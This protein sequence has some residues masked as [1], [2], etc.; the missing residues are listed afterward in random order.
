MLMSIAL[1]KCL[2]MDLRVRKRTAKNGSETDSPKVQNEQKKWKN[3]WK[4]A[5]QPAPYTGLSG[6]SGP[7]SRKSL[8]SVSWGLW[9]RSPEKSLKSLGNG[10]GSLRKVSGKCQKSLFGL[11][12]R[13]FGDFSG[14]RGRTPHF[15]DV[16]GFSG[17]KG[18]RD[19]CKG[20]AGS[21]SKPGENRR[22]NAKMIG[23]LFVNRFF[24]PFI[25]FQWSF[26]RFI[27]LKRFW[28]VLL[29]LCHSVCYDRKERRLGRA[30]LSHGC[31]TSRD[32]FSRSWLLA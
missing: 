5:N 32:D 29:K 24:G 22:K 11:F 15:R 9:P 6:P 20:R 28:F 8:E 23:V 26:Y 30:D 27:L 12:P 1:H 7:K 14:S 19:L 17:P 3:G 13:L 25:T 4:L 18:P 21:Q 31:Q 2:A 16:F 10:L